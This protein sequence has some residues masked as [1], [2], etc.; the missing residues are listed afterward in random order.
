MLRTINVDGKKM[1]AVV[2]S[3]VCD[4]GDIQSYRR[5]LLDMMECALLEKDRTS[6]HGIYGYELRAY[7]NLISAF[8]GEI[9]DVNK[10]RKK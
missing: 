8:D 7:I 4:I 9:Q 2:L 10:G 1:V 3:E 6:N 5:A